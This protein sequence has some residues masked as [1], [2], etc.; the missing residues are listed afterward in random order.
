MANTWNILYLSNQAIIW[1]G[2]NIYY[3]C[4]LIMVRIF[5]RGNMCFKFKII[6]IIMYVY[7]RLTHTFNF[8]RTHGLVPCDNVYLDE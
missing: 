4:S 8:M 3:V 7:V 6:I 2:M 1:A 5:A